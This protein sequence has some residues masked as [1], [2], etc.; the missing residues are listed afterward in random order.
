M[1]FMRMREDRVHFYELSGTKATN[2]IRQYA[3]MPDSTS[4][5]EEKNVLMLYPGSGHERTIRSSKLFLD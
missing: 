4:I 1:E 2:C 5:E 3:K